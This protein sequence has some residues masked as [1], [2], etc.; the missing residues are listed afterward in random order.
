LAERLRKAVVQQ[1]F[2]LPDG[3]RLNVSCSIGFA[4][5]PLGQGGWQAAVDL[6][7]QALY[8]AK[9]RG[10][11]GWCGVLHL[12]QAGMDTPFASLDEAIEQDLVESLH[13][14]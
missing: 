7:D 5:Y 14:S 13:S 12:K 3:Q 2:E 11:N 10:R 9:A 4:P 6:A 8:R 1:P